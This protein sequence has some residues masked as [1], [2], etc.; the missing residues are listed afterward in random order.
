MSDER[1]ALLYALRDADDRNRALMEKGEM[2]KNRAKNMRNRLEGGHIDE[3]DDESIGEALVSLEVDDAE[4]DAYITEFE[5]VSNLIQY[6]NS[7][8]TKIEGR[9]I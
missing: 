6:V 9:G 3:N 2:L 5:A 7:E 4:F 1:W 8:L